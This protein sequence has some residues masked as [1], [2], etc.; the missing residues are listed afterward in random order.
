M[1]A[2]DFVTIN[3][4]KY[5]EKA[6]LYVTKAM[7]EAQTASTLLKIESITS[8][9]NALIRF[10]DG[11]FPV[12]QDDLTLVQTTKVTV[13]AADWSKLKG[14]RNACMESTN[15]STSLGQRHNSSMAITA[16]DLNEEVKNIE[17]F[18]RTN[19]GERKNQ[20]KLRW[21]NVPMFLMEPLIEVGQYGE[22]K[23]ET[24]NYL[25]GMTTND[26][27]DCLKRHLNAF[28]SPYQEDN[29]PESKVNH[30][31]HVAWN[32]LVALHM[33]KTRPELDDRFC[34]EPATKDQMYLQA[35]G[36]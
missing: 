2:G 27:L 26:S 10:E 17:A 9:D 11:P 34:P 14:S 31:A 6:G 24:F 4:F 13:R 25:K 3:S 7:Y 32:A 12:K 18:T 16:A 29:D 19:L 8:A 15:Q 23:Y 35:R 28:E 33:L 36:E 20:G 30:L 22:S 1:N 21:R 5:T